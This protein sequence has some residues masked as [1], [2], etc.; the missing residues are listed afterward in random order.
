[1]APA[2][3]Q[4]IRLTDIQQAAVDAIVR[5][6]NFLLISEG[7]EGQ[8]TVCMNASRYVLQKGIE[9]IGQ[10]ANIRDLLTDVVIDLHTKKK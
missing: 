3:E 1:M 7:A 6:N 4:R 2:K 5:H 10:H 8:T 9:D